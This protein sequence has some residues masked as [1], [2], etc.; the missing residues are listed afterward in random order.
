V[1]ITQAVAISEALLKRQKSDGSW[2]NSFTD[3]REDEFQLQ[4]RLQTEKE[5]ES[6]RFGGLL[7]YVLEQL[8]AS[9]AGVTSE[10]AG[11]ARREKR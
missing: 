11:H 5:I 2:A 7:P 1:G 6:L 9:G 8:L 10:V 4:L 3:G